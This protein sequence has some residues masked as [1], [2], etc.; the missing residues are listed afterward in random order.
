MREFLRDL[1]AEYWDGK[2]GWPGV[3]IGLLLVVPAVIFGTPMT[4]AVTLACMLACGIMALDGSRSIWLP[5]IALACLFAF[6][7]A[8]VALELDRRATI[9][10]HAQDLRNDARIAP[11]RTTLDTVAAEQRRQ[12]E[13][14]ARADSASEAK[15]SAAAQREAEAASAAMARRMAI[16][17]WI[18]A[19]ETLRVKCFNRCN[20][21][22]T[23]D[24][25]EWRE[26]V[27]SFVKMYF[28][29][30]F[31]PA[32]FGD[33][34]PEPR[35]SRERRFAQPACQELYWE[36][37]TDLRRIRNYL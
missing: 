7:S 18:A 35:M 15:R 34:Y 22:L 26:D 19:G 4:V 14:Q 9:A 11:I 28:D 24:V 1:I 3:A 12:R 29:P 31:Q 10:Q 2:S 8:A 23:A 27:S 13:A 30:S 37:E 20:E 17:P 16:S 33:Q 6:T 21:Q 25:E 32:R 36:I 5:R